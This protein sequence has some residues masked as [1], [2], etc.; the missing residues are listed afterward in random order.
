MANNTIDL[1]FITDDSQL[2]K[3]IKKSKRLERDIL[4]LAL[5]EKKG[6]ITTDQYSRSVG[7]LASELQRTSGGLIQAR[8]SV[9]SYSREVRSSV[10]SME[11]LSTATGQVGRRM[12]R[13][14][15]MYQQAGYQIG[16]FIVQV[17][18]GQNALV[19]FGQQATQLAGTMTLLGGKFLAIG[20]VLGIAIP[21]VTAAG[22][23]FLKARNN[24]KEAAK[25]VGDFEKALKSARS[26]VSGMEEDLRLLS[27]GFEST[28]RLTLEDQ[29][30]KAESKVSRLK[31]SLEELL[32]SDQGRSE[33]ARA[34]AEQQEVEAAKEALILAQQELANAVQLSEQEKERQRNASITNQLLQ[35]RQDL[36]S[37]EREEAK[38][39]ARDL[40]EGLSKTIGMSQTVKNAT[41]EYVNE[42]AAAFIKAKK[43]R[44]QVGEAAYEALVF[45]GV[46]MSS[47]VDAASKAAATLAANL[48]ISL[49]EAIKLKALSADPL[50]PFGGPGRFIPKDSLPWDTSTSSSSGGGGGSSI[51][52]QDPLENLRERIEL[53]TKL[54]GLSKERQQV[55]RLIANSN[56]EYSQKAIDQAVAELEAYNQIVDKRKEIQGIMDTAKSSIEDGFMAMIE[57]TKSVED[58]FKDMAKNIIKELYQ[59]LVMKQMVS[60]VSGLLGGGGTSGGILG[61]IGGAIGKLFSFDGGGYTGS[62]PRSGGLDGRGGYLAMVHPRE[63]VVDHTKAGNP[64]VDGGVT[65]VQNFNFQANGDESVKRIIA[66][67]APSIINASKTAVINERRRCGPMKVAFG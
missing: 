17:Q 13:T 60:D 49:Q 40:A 52:Q 5:A 28:F 27:S 37:K 11:A 23:A 29:V 22:A 10:Q 35:V 47:G 2:D 20:T 64:S 8:N 38:A 66:Q 33:K 25:G 54:L 1:K 53:D 19:A 61:S 58:A 36:Q 24:S 32:G 50:D 26:E 14:G 12:S 31:Q 7:K 34:R 63:T 6:K 43:L 30:K 41:S 9:N 48:N 55:E 42:M 44:E 51:E 18:S 62:G 45:A 46:D 16:D 57:G 4:N 65:V 39:L 56:I 15:V 67:A 59:V 21:L 3:S